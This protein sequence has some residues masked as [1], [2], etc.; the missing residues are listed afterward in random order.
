MKNLVNGFDERT[1][2]RYDFVMVMYRYIYNEVGD[3][4]DI[5][6]DAPINAICRDGISNKIRECYDTD[7]T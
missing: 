4:S 7:I 6:T 3:L 5:S 1:C 2:W